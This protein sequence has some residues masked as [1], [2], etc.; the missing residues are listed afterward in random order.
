MKKKN[1]NTILLIHGKRFLK[2]EIK[3]NLLSTKIPNLREEIQIFT[4]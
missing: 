1:L 4:Y 2:N 3:I